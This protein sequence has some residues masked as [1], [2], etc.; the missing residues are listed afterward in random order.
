MEPTMKKVRGVWT[1]QAYKPVRTAKQWAKKA[2]AEQKAL[3]VKP[4]RPEPLSPD[5]DRFA[6][7]VIAVMRS[8]KNLG[9][10]L[11]AIRKFASVEI[12]H[13]TLDLYDE[14]WE[15]PAISKSNWGAHVLGAHFYTLFQLKSRS[16][17]SVPHLLR[18]E[19]FKIVAGRIG[20]TVHYAVRPFT[21]EERGQTKFGFGKR[22]ATPTKRAT[23][24]RSL[25][26]KSSRTGQLAASVARLMRG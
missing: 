4:P 14:L 19:P 11:I 3:P 25:P 13:T 26:R 18:D 24:R 23:K 22:R 8:E 2:A 1:E 10:A 20:A 15:H 21:A 17:S 9:D 16:A 6:D 7:R 12:S 5:L